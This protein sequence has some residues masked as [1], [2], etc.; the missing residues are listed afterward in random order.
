M[1]SDSK[2][3]KVLLDEI[4]EFMARETEEMSDEEFLQELD[5]ES[6]FSHVEELKQ[7]MEE[8]AAQVRSERLADARTRYE[9][10]MSDGAPRKARPRPSV[11]EIK[12]RI[13]EVFANRGEM[14]AG[15]AYRNGEYQSDEDLFSLWDHLC[16]LGAVDDK[17]A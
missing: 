13:Q 12:Q 15:V 3:P 8:R 14:P 1:T 11:V 17:E 5:E 4:A 7:H 9:S 10:A 2:N 6:V 16:E